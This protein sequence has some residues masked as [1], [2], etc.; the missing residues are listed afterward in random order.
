MRSLFLLLTFVSLSLLSIAEEVTYRLVEYDARKGDYVL[1]ACGRRPVGSEVWFENEYGATTG[2]RYNQLPRNRQA[3]L[4]L[5]GWD[6]CTVDSITFS[7]CSNI[8][9]GTIGV[10]VV[11]GE[12]QLFQQKPC[13]FASKDWYGMWV[14]KDHAMYVDVTKAMTQKVVVPDEA[15]FSVTLRGGTPEGS[16]YIHSFT[17]H[18]TPGK[19]VQ[20]ESPMGYCFEK[21]EKK[22][23]LSEGDVVMLYRSGDAACDIDGMEKSHYLDAVGLNSTSDVTEPEVL[24][25]TLV[26]DATKTH[27]MLVDQYDRQLCATKAQQ[28]EWC[29]QPSEQANGGLWDITLGYDGATIASTNTKYGTLRYNAPAG[30]WPRF[31]NYT[32]KTL[33]LPYIYKRVKQN[34]PVLST[35]IYLPYTERTVGLGEQD[36][37]IVRAAVQPQ[38]ANDQ[39]ILWKS[40]DTYVASVRDGI[41][42]PNAPGQAVITAKASDGGCEA[43]ILLTVTGDDPNA[44]SAP[45]SQEEGREGKFVEGRRIMIRKAGHSYSLQGTRQQ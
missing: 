7:M 13:E 16:V 42:I 38:K 31:W 11:A 22:S 33:P 18:Y 45:A 15:E 6:G 32:S 4:H 26:R 28:L 3:T 36:T 41:I 29:L 17:I 10:T 37:L 34:S 5:F 40:S 8:S 1:S 20:T 30:S 24:C 43:S 23:T 27:W 35:D 39:R 2:N 21:M 25:F 12:E 14:S 9:S 19:G 44:I